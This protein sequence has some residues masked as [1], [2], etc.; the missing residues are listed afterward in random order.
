MMSQWGCA[1]QTGCTRSKGIRLFN[2]HVTK[3]LKDV[4]GG[5]LPP[6]LNSSLSSIPPIK[7]H[8]KHQ[9]LGAT[10][11]FLLRSP[12]VF[13]QDETIQNYVKEGKA[14]LVQGDALVKN[15]VR[16]AWSEASNGGP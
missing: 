2:V 1:A 10:V 7:P 9:T 5:G 11:T 13:D 16:R 4:V 15:D 14:R 12:G 3:H 8:G 6:L